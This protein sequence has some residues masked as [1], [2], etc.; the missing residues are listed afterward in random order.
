MKPIQILHNQSLLDIAIQHTGSVENA[1]K[2]AELNK[3]PVSE[4]LTAGT[5]I[6]I[7]D[8]VINDESILNYYKAKEIQPATSLTDV[9]SVIEYKGIGYMI[10]EDN[11]KV[12]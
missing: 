7:P 3:I 12:G 9:Q 10:I 4:T 8:H 5:S 1:F 6:L 2:I 11:F